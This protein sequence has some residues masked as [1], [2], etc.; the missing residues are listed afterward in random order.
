M[1]DIEKRVSGMLWVQGGG[2]G[3]EV[4]ESEAD[5]RS[6]RTERD[7]ALQKTRDRPSS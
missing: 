3:L 7:S 2:L 5:I 4:R 1:Q 6:Q